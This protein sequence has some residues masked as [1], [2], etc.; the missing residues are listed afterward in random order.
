MVPFKI[1]VLYPKSH[2]G[3]FC[4][5]INRKIWHFQD[6]ARVDYNKSKQSWHILI[7]LDLENYT[8]FTN[9]VIHE[10]FHLKIES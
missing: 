10:V 7:A 5:L 8:E 2:F 1:Y 4:L 6:T 9:A 3:E